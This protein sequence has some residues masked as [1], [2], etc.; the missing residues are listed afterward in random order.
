MP[1]DTRLKLAAP[2]P[3]EPGDALTFGVLEFRL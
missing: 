2:V 3:N 1:P